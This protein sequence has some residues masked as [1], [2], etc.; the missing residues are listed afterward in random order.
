MYQDVFANQL[1]RDTCDLS[2][3][4]A[5]DPSV[6]Q[7]QSPHRPQHERTPPYAALHLLGTLDQSSPEYNA[8]QS[9]TFIRPI[10]PVANAPQIQTQS[11]R[12]M[13]QD[14]VT[15]RPPGDLF[16]VLPGQVH[17]Q[18]RQTQERQTQERQ[19]QERQSRAQNPETDVLTLLANEDTDP[20]T[21]RTNYTPSPNHQRTP[22][23]QTTDT[24]HT[25]HTAAQVYQSVFAVG[26]SSGDL[27]DLSM[28]VASPSQTHE[29]T[30]ARSTVHAQNLDTDVLTLLANEDIACKDTLMYTP[31]TRSCGT[32]SLANAAHTQHHSPA[33]TYQ[34]V[35]TAGATQSPT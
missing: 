10:D 13:Y 4:V 22:A 33:Q 24:L 32:D 29:E 18:E 34:S 19:T 14:V 16:N 2:N 1:L 31:A 9:P 26:K 6:P 20:Q 7:I 5:E 30:K 28:V 27:C 21:S 35:L 8:A 11:S 23:H 15:V 17:A 3:V 25:H 12:Q